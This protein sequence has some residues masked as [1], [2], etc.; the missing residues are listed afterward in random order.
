MYPLQNNN[1]FTAPGPSMGSDLAGTTKEYGFNY[2][3]NF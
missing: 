1:D 3:M 2:K